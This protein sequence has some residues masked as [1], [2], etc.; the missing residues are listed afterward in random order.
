MVNVTI[1]FFMSERRQ[2]DRNNTL[3]GCQFKNQ[4]FASRKFTI[5]LI[6]LSDR[7]NRSISGNLLSIVFWFILT[8]GKYTVF[9]LLLNL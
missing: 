6:V 5:K 1:D 3:I 2:R 8:S 9:V 4:I 7:Q